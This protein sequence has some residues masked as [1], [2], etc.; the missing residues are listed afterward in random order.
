MKGNETKK[1][2]I[3]VGVFAISCFCAGAQNPV[4]FADINL[5]HAFGNSGG[6]AGGAS[7]NFQN[8]RHF[9][10]L[11]SQSTVRLK[12]YWASTWIPIPVF[13]Q[14]SNLNEYAFLYGWRFVN[15]NHAFSFSLGPSYNIFTKDGTVSKYGGAAFETNIKWFKAEKQRMRIYGLI[16]FGRPTGF[17]SSI[18]FKLF[19][20]ISKESYFGLGVS[21]GFGFHKVYQPTF[22]LGRLP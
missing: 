4:I 1:G 17:G 13:E 21:Y 18:G 5:G 16:P 9:F 22:K 3:L 11:R 7:L 15:D 19:G 8:N 2:F 10:T 14:T 12:S 6:L 20:N